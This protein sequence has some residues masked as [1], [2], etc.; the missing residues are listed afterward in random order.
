VRVVRPHHVADDPRALLVRPVRLHAGL[1]HPV[2]DAAVDRLE[3]VAHVRQRARDDHAHRV[4]EEARAH[5]L[6]ELARLDAACA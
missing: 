2:E 4:V 1:V 5:L 6:L 3:P